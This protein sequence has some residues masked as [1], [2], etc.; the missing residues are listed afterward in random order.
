MKAPPAFNEH[1][2]LGQIAAVFP[3]SMQIFEV[4]RLDYRCRGLRELGEAFA[5]TEFSSRKV[6]NDIK[7][8]RISDLAVHQNRNEYSLADLVG[9]LFAAHHTHTRTELPRLASLL[10]RVAQ[11]HGAGQPR[12]DARAPRAQI[13]M[14]DLGPS[15]WFGTGIHDTSMQADDPGAGV[16]PGPSSL[17]GSTFKGLKA[18]ELPEREWAFLRSSV[19]EPLDGKHQNDTQGQRKTNVPWR[20]L[21][22]GFGQDFRPNHP[23]Y[24][25]CRQPKPEWEHG[26]K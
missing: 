16:E 9:D 17:P 8:L 1:T 15:L 22:A 18:A 10:E 13:G 26:F 5:G 25:T 11:Y 14:V 19:D 2:R 20:G 4:D 3:P 24:R 12:V 6:I 23:D 7:V 21:A